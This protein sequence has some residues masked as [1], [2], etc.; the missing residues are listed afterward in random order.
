M[1]VSSH[2]DQEFL[3]KMKALEDSIQSMAAFQEQFALFFNEKVRRLTPGTSCVILLESLYLSQKLQ[4]ALCFTFVSRISY[5]IFQV[6]F[7]LNQLLISNYPCKNVKHLCMGSFSGEQSSA[8]HFLA[9]TLQPL[10]AFML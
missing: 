2:L 7:S 10:E 9:I 4:A 5:L 3:P 6:T 1:T 8:S